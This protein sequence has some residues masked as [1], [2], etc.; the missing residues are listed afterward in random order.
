MQIVFNIIWEA[1]KESVSITLL[2]LLLMAVVESINISSSGRLF[3]RLHGKPV[4]EVALACL[5]GAI[6]GCA[7]GFVVV[8]LFTHR[9]LSFGALIG[10]MIATFGDEALF[11][12]AQDPMQAL[13]LTGVLFAIGFVVGL[14]LLKVPENKIVT[15]ENHD[16]VIHEEHRHERPENHGKSFRGRMSHYLREHVWEHVIKQHALKLFLYAFGT[17]L[18]LGIL[19]HFVDLQAIME[20]NAW[21]KWLLLLIAVGVG[22][23]PVS[24]PHLIFVMLFLQGNIPFVVLLANS[25]A[26]NGHAGIPLLAQSKQ[27]FLIMK[28]ITMALGLLIGSLVLAFSF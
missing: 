1:L 12:A 16:F 7:G 5:L 14:L 3:K 23:L 8:S 22:F 17:L 19:N 2:V 26:Q 6:P 9:L 10:G 13:I 20:H 24:G 28:G 11:L 25:I 21:T 27:N 4:A 18:V 15:F